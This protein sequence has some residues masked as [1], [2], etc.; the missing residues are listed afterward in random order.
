[1]ID[2]SLTQKQEMLQSLAREFAQNEISPIVQIIEESNNSEMEP[3]DFCKNVFYKGSE[4]GFIS[5]NN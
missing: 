1:M 5:C 4:L 2:F 3:W